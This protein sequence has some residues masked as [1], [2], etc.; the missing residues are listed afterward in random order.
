M[1]SRLRTPSL[2]IL[3]LFGASAVFGL[4]K[5]GGDFVAN[6]AAVAADVNAQFNTIYTA[7]NSGA[8]SINIDG[9]ANGSGN[10]GYT[11]GNLGVG[12]ASPLV[13]FQVNGGSAVT[14]AAATGFGVFGATTG[15]HIAVDTTQIQAKSNATTAANLAINPLGG[16]VGIGTA[17]PGYQFTVR[18]NAASAIPM[19]VN[20]TSGNNAL[21]VIVDPAGN[22]VVVG[23]NAGNA[24]VVFASSGNSYVTNNLGVG[25]A[26]P[27][28]K[29]DV[30]GDMNVGPNQSI[31]GVTTLAANFPSTTDRGVLSFATHG[32]GVNQTMFAA[33]TAAP[34]NSMQDFF[35]GKVSATAGGAGTVRVRMRADGSALFNGPGGNCEIGDDATPSCTSD[36]RLKTNFQPLVN[37]MDKI[38]RIRGL[39]FSWRETPATRRHLG[40]LAQQVEAVFPEIVKTDKNTGMKKVEHSALIPALIEG[41]RE[42]KSE[43]DTQVLALQKRA[44][45]AEQ[46]LS[47]V[48]SQSNRDKAAADARI[49]ALEKRLAQLEAN[50]KIIIS[51]R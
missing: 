49:A 47:V 13:K 21:S 32:S 46:K 19:R 24:R 51:R 8:N 39:Y 9:W 1:Y 31:T 12:I 48:V 30:N 10:L 18:A 41:I 7:L 28:T 42:L 50:Q 34:A 33:W 37:A 36:E 14:L 22:E 17:A 38:L 23:D 43:K 27:T 2:I 11:G 6:N 35:V 4:V 5:P 15:N 25:T 40:V 29:L 3:A 44:T 16:N 20:N 45:E 26:S